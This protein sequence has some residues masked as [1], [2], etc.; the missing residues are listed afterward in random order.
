MAKKQYYCIDF[1]NM[2]KGF[3]GLFVFDTRKEAEDNFIYL[4]EGIKYD[5]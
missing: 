1:R 4:K 3:H 2:N 5:N